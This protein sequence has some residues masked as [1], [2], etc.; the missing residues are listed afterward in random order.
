[1]TFQIL[2]IID[3]MLEIYQKPRGMDR[4]QD[5][6][7]TL[8]GDSKGDL[9]LP[10]SG[11][12]P[13]AKDHIIP[14]LLELKDLEAEILIKKVLEKLND[15]F[16]NEKK[17]I[18]FKVALNLS[19]DLKGGWTNRFTTDFDSKFKINALVNRGF[20]TPIFWTS[21]NFDAEIIQKRTL[22][23]ALRSYYWLNYP[24]PNTLQQH[25]QQELFVAQNTLLIKHNPSPLE[26]LWTVH[27]Q[28]WDNFY[29]KNKETDNFHVIFNFFYGDAVCE[30]LGFP[31]HGI[32]EEMAGFEYCQTS[33]SK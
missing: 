12:N 5:Y 27:W 15:Q 14:K 19:D 16:K 31:T 30:S 22:E 10:I 7:K 3:I 17:D 26:S 33:K 21:E 2:P 18:H 11:F 23:Y 32:E 4:F 13:M 8:Q 20:C 25:I 28:K 1:M 24:K 29:Q 9:S 6:I